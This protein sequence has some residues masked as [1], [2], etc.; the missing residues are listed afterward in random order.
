MYAL[1]EFDPAIAVIKRPPIYALER[2][3]TGIGWI[4]S[5]TVIIII[6]IVTHEIV[7]SKDATG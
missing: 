2:T 7:M 6:I 3:A 1:A 4:K 5:I